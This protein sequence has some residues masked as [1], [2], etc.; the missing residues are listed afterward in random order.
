MVFVRDMASHG[1]S[2]LQWMGLYPCACTQH[3]LYS[4]GYR[5][6]EEAMK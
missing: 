6:K 1:L 3:P 5:E 4:V 2:V